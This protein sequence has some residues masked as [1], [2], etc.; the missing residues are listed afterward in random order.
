MSK[1]F[2]SHSSK[3]NEFVGKL[4]HDLLVNGIPIWLDAYELTL[5]DSLYDKIFSGIKESNYII[6]VISENYNTTIW[7]SKEFRAILSKE[8]KDNTK[9]LIP[10][11]IDNSEVPLEIADRL[12]QNFENE[13]RDSIKH[14]VRFF[15]KEDF[16][17]TSIPIDKRQIILNFSDFVHL[18]VDLFKSLLPDLHKQNTTIQKRQIF[19]NAY[20]SIDALLKVGEKKL[21][22]IK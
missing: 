22:I 19:F 3:D 13:Y 4:S 5:G 15:K 12:Y 21:A 20:S 18:D 6:V 16:S 7:T 17:I 9:Y 8:D 1:I 10:I 11:K 14:L 2:I